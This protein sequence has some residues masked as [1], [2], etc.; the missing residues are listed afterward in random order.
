MLFSGISKAG[1]AFCLI[2]SG[3][4]SC[5]QLPH[6]LMHKD[7]EHTDP[8]AYFPNEATSLS[9]SMQP[10][11]VICPVCES[12]GYYIQS[13]FVQN[14]ALGSQNIL[15]SQYVCTNKHEWLIGQHT[16]G[17]SVLTNRYLLK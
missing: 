1:I 17:G 7:M 12:A 8:K 6:I 2:L 9:D 3:M 14:E 15:Y 10:L 16:V 5:A 11:N 13:I 4:T